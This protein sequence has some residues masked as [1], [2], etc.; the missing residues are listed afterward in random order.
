MRKYVNEESGNIIG[1]EMNF[2]IE[3]QYILMG[4]AYVEKTINKLILNN[5]NKSKFTRS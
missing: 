5:V 2:K 1:K 4:I 3:V